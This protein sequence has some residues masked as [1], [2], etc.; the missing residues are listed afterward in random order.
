MIRRNIVRSG[1][2]ESADRS[3]SRILLLELLLQEVKLVER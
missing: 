3:A 2:Q 1:S